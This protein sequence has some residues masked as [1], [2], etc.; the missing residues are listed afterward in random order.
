MIDSR[1]SVDAALAWLAEHQLATG[2]LPSFAS[3]LGETEP[4][5]EPDQLNFVTALCAEVLDTIDDP[6]AR[7]IVDAAVERVRLE[8][9]FGAR[10]RYWS[11]SND[12]VEFTPPDADDTACCSMAVGLR[13]D[14]TSAN[15][16]HLLAAT[17]PEGRF[18]TWLIP[19]GRATDPR[20][21][22]ALRS[23]RKATTR[24]LRAELWAS[25]EA[26]AHDVD[27][28]VNANVCRYLGPDR[29][30]R[31]A[32]EWVA[33]VVEAGV[34]THDKWHRSPYSLWAAVAAGATGGITRFEA[35]GSIVVDRISRAV[36]DDGT[37]GRDLDT[38]LALLAVQRFGGPQPLQDRLAAGLVARQLASGAWRREVCYHGGPTEVFGWASEALTTAYAA[39]ALATAARD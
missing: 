1:S 17:T 20:V 14:D 39:A 34:A 10:W 33:S 24:R 4:V 13:G 35:L 29:A 9:S 37:V 23:E 6:R 22:W 3:A 21:W 27:A 2:E 32:V 30:P 31:G 19:H 28:V 11:R 7:T 16:V 25:T 18:Y 8:R 5:W 12:R 15:V 36:L 26:A 38:A